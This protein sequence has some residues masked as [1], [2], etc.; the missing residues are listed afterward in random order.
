MLNPV[1]IETFKPRMFFW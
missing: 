1:N